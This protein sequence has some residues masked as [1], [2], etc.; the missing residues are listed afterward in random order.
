[1]NKPYASPRRCS[2][3]SLKRNGGGQ[4]CFTWQSLVRI[5][6]RYN[7][8][9]PHDK[10]TLYRNRDQLWRAIKRKMPECDDEKCWTTSRFLAPQDRAALVEDFKPPLPQGKYAWLNTDDID[11]VLQGYTKVFPDFL[12]MGAH[13]I[14]F[15]TYDHNFNPLRLVL[16]SRAKKAG[17][18]LNLDDSSQDGSHWVAVYFDIAHKTMEYYDSYGDKAPQPVIKFFEALRQRGWKYK[19]NRKVHQRK[20]SECGVYSIHFIVRRLLGKTFD[21]TVDKIIRDAEMNENRLKFFD[22]MEK[23]NNNI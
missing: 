23:Y 5:A 18:V 14:D 16:A 15:Q 20:N 10:I 1:M 21:E 17:L 6:R 13:P 2:P 12:Y 22:P 3:L 4:S 9:N 19:E 8:A 11:R 7:D